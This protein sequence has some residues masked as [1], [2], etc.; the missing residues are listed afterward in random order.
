M[1]L[2]LFFMS[3]VAAVPAT[4][5]VDIGLRVTGASLVG[6]KSFEK[7]ASPTA[8]K[9]LLEVD[10]GCSFDLCLSQNLP[11]IVNGDQL[12]EDENGC[13]HLTNSSAS[14]LYDVPL[15]GK[16]LFW[17][18]L[19]VNCSSKDSGVTVVSL[20][21]V[22][23]VDGF[24]PE[25]SPA[26]AFPLATNVGP[27]G[28]NIPSSAIFALEIPDVGNFGSLS[29]SFTFD[30]DPTARIQVNL[31]VNGLSNLYG[32]PDWSAVGTSGT[33]I[34][35][36]QS[37]A[38]R[39]SAVFFE[40]TNLDAKNVSLVDSTISLQD[41]N[42]IDTSKQ[43]KDCLWQVPLLILIN[44]QELEVRERSEYCVFGWCYYQIASG[45]PN[46][47]ITVSATKPG[48][49][50]YFQANQLPESVKGAFGTRLQLPI[51]DYATGITSALRPHYFMGVQFPFKADNVTL[52]LSVG[53]KIDDDGL[54]TGAIVGI[55]VGSTLAGALVI[56]LII[57]LYKTRNRTS[58]TSYRTI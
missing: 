52:K 16:G 33:N 2:L 29:A 15:L 51:S 39:G 50:V 25:C 58:R 56:V 26:S 48:A 22:C 30:G 46:T 14:G 23:K 36:V 18:N 1:P 42:V 6:A 35:V 13:V 45:L 32:D 5:T 28:I 12:I 24:G 49:Y 31:I 11:G 44:D 54:S 27:P 3:I 9:L 19:V 53:H 34:T 40:M 41:C 8:P 43:G 10:P 57:Y 47:Q 21:G 37:V 55:A 4:T 38:L 17:V 20:E 7:F